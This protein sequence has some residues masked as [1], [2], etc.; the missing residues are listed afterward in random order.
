[1]ERCKELISR[2]D[3]FHIKHVCRESNVVSNSL[4]QQASGYEITREKFAV[5]KELTSQSILDIQVIGDESAEAKGDETAVSDW[6][7]I[8]QECITD[9]GAQG[10]R[11][12]GSNH[13]GTWFLTVSYIRGRWMGC[14]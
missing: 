13:C 7:S 3:T 4:A 1:M 6:R 14:Y 10:T 8:I 11:K 9:L 5:L 2:L 12:Y